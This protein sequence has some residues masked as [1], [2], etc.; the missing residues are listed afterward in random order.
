MDKQAVLLD[1]CMRLEAAGQ[2]DDWPEVSA[3]DHDIGDAMSR[4]HA[5]KTWTAAEHAALI[6][7]KLA[8][9]AIRER[10]AN[11]LA[12]LDG[13]MADLREQKPGWMAYA[14]NDRVHGSG[15]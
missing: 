6:R 11:A 13:R 5:E 3:V 4:L 7:L 15:A 10:C 9:L 2:A 14:M 8:H 1:L 12:R